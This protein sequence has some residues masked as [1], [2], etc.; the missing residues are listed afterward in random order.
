MFFKKGIVTGDAGF[1]GVA[2]VETN[3]EKKLNV[4]DFNHKGTKT[5]RIDY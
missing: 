5:R 3:I 2:L 1:I 4:Y